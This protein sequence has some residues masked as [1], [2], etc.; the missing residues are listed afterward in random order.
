MKSYLII[1]LL[2]ITIIL[3]CPYKALLAQEPFRLT[4]LRIAGLSASL[5]ANNILPP[6]ITKAL[7]I[8]RYYIVPT[9]AF[10]EAK[11]KNTI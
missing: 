5:L 10:I 7:D 8:D 3:P 4:Y 1:R 6:E 9:A 2:L 11:K